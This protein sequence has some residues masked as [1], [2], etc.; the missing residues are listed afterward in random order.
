LHTI[1]GLKDIDGKTV[2][3]S[4]LK[5]KVV[6]AMNAA[7]ACGY[8]KRGYDIMSE[9]AKMFPDQV[10]AISFPSNQFGAQESG[11]PTEIKQFVN[12]KFNNPDIVIMEK[13]DV[14]GSNANPVF[15]LAK[16]AG[17]GEPK[18]NFDGR[19]IFD[20]TGKPVERLT[21]QS[22]KE[23]IVAAIKKYL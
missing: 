7:C 14:V 15:K 10:T 3:L 2:D 19:I 6:L 8:T 23:E 17:L 16:D 9:V 22:T 11:S 5:G 20:K 1:T 13:S 18:W 21:N 4:Q 12:S